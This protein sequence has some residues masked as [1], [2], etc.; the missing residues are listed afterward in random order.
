ME[1]RARFR[2]HMMDESNPSDSNSH[3]SRAGLAPAA[4]PRIPPA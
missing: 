3:P 4:A 1:K 2:A